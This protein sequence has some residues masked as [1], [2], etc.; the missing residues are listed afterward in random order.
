MA[1]TTSTINSYVN[2]FISSENTK[3]VTP[4]TTRKTKYSN[5][6]SA[7]ST[8]ST[9]LTS[10]KSILDTFTTSDSSSLFKAKSAV[11]S[12]SN[13]VSAAATSSAANSSYDIRVS[14][15]AK[16]DVALSSDLTAADSNSA[17]GTQSFIIKTGDGT[18]GEFTSKV[19][20]TLGTG[21]TNQSVMQKISAA[22]NADKAVV[23]STDK[24]A[25]SDYT[26]GAGKIK[27]DLNG[28][29]TT[30]SYNGGGTYENLVDELVTN[31]NSGVSGVTAEKVITDGKVNLKMT[32]SDSSKYISTSAVEGGD[33]ISDLGI[34]VTKEKGASGLV[35][36][37]SLSPD[38]TS[39]Q[40]TFTAKNTGLG[41]RIKEISD[42]GTSTA[43]S[44]IG[45]N[46]GTSRTQ[47]VQQ[48]GA[49]TAGFMYSDITS[50]GNSLNSKMVFN[51]LSVQRNSN[52]V[53]DIATGVTF[54][55]KSVMQASDT[56]VNVQV[57][58]D[59]S[60]IRSNIDS[61]IS[62]FNDAY[63]YLKTGSAVTKTTR[64][65]LAS[66]TNTSSLLSTLGSLG[67][68]KVSG[69]GTNELNML[70]QI[71][72][73]FNSSTGLSVSDSTKLDSQISDNASQVE[74][75]FNSANGVATSLSS[76][77]QPYLGT[78]GYLNTSKKSFDDTITYLADR[79][80][81]TQTRINKNADSLRTRYQT[82]QAQLATLT[83]TAA[84]YGVTL[85][86]YSSY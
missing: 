66:D 24:T 25:S 47:F 81:A 68:S 23:T 18:T 50:E 58:V 45:M 76:K 12:N 29:E 10:L 71:G 51:G 8:I 2:S 21:E 56:T 33:I 31:I 84:M 27:I 83:N 52:T 28:V 61:F 79:V 53:S 4:L 80:T 9:K 42:S 59:N 5:L 39:S 57:D 3:S 63:T 11:S 65:V 78:A 17:T 72:I 46:F 36:A 22:I 41:Y 77:I 7:Y 54:S 16:S 60:T 67:Y 32:V 20:V 74:A 40:L 62:K 15:L 30:V 19:D 1:L 13:F 37:S 75:L 85:T 34:G 48:A 86:D 69:L 6:S 82:L 44:S 43:L 55:L 64:G 35:T 38:S 14:Q 73:S 49:D 26:L 70:N